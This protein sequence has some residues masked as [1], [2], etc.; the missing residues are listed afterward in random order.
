MRGVGMVE[1][2]MTMLPNVIWHNWCQA[3]SYGKSEWPSYS[4]MYIWL[5]TNHWDLDL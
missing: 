3:V 2:D 5:H 1:P 4:E